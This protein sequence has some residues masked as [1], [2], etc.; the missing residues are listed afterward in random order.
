LKNTLL[1][2]LLICIG[3][4]L[5]F[6]QIQLPS[7][8]SSVKLFRQNAEIK[9]SISFTPEIGN[10][11]IVLT[12]ISTF[13]IPSSVQIQ[14]DNA[15]ADI[16]S[17][18]YKVNSVMQ[19]STNPVIDNLRIKL[20]AAIEELAVI[21][22]KIDG[23]D[24]S[25]QVLELPQDVDQ[26]NISFTAQQLLDIANIYENKYL[27]IKKERRAL[28]KKENVLDQEVNN[29]RAELQLLNANVDKPNGS[30]ILQINA[31][32]NNAINLEFN[33]LVGNASWKPFYDLRSEG[34]TT[35]VNLEYKASVAQSTGVS[36]KNVPITIS[37]GN[38]IQNNNRP[39]LNP[40]YVDVYKRNK[41]EVDIPI[42]NVSNVATYQLMETRKRA[43]PT[44]PAPKVVNPMTEN[45]LSSEFELGNLQS[46]KSDGKPNLIKLANYELET[47]YIYHSVP[48]KD[49]GAYLLAKISNWTGYNLIK[50]KANIFFEGG[51]VGVT[52]INPEITA[53]QILI[54]MGR[55]N[56]IVIQRRVSTN[57][58]SSKIIAANKKESLGYDIIVKNKKSIPITI[59]VLDQVPLSKNS[60]TEVTLEEKGSAVYTEEIG[61]L[62]W[63]WEIGA[64]ETQV[65][66]FS[67]TVKY[68]KRQAIIGIK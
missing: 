60:V 41:L 64:G 49:I 24:I 18:K 62:L 15:D 65:E 45:Q 66:A 25:L 9:R 36:W 7:N 34:I 22:D 32:D 50:G 2:A 68:P 39:I 54:S 27:E 29:L 67:Y 23:I 17:V 44:S 61:K 13:I 40:L 38:P 35:N 19:A 37:T 31:K 56:D 58:V 52:N 4:N 16:L 6:A 42:Q 59:E 48:K 10:Q 46:I 26:E 47:K 43:K 55:D 63:T 3:F 5:S 30:I 8:I 14:L 33:Y 57:F 20:S 53:D 51:F 1:V 21:E 12:G 28:Y 11:E